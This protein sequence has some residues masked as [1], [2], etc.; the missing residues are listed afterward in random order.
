MLVFLENKWNCSKNLDWLLKLKPM[1]ENPDNLTCNGEP[2]D[3]KPLYRIAEFLQVHI[4]TSPFYMYFLYLCFFKKLRQEC[5]VHCNCSMPHVVK[6]YIHT[7]R[8][9]PIIQ[10][11]CS[12]RNLVELPSK[13]PNRTKILLLQDN[14]IT[15]LSPLRDNPNYSTVH[16]IYLDDNQI[17]SI[18]GL[19]GTEW[20]VR[21]RI[22]SLR[23]NELTQLPTYALDNALERNMNMPKAVRIFLGGN[24]WRCDCIYTPTFQVSFNKNSCYSYN[25]WFSRKFF[26]NIKHKSLMLKM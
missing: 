19:E 11:N 6:D 3:G 4:Y 18:E 21:F 10:V 7:G 14:F 15:D 25:I 5:P 22:L 16:D 2:Y 13:L 26:K 17:R 20:F 23:G 24:P 8:L 12:R 1:V 9:E